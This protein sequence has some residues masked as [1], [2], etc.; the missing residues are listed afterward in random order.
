[1]FQGK[2]AGIELTNQRHRNNLILFL[3]L[4]LNVIIHSINLGVEPLWYDEIVSVKASLLDFGHVKHMAEWD[5]NPPFYYY[6]LWVWTKLFGITELAVR[7]LNL[8]FH[9]G[10]VILLFHFVSKN[11]GNIIAITTT[12]LFSFNDFVFY[13][14]HEARC[15]TLT[16]FL[17]IASGA[18]FFKVLRNPSK[19]TVFSLGLVNFLIIYTH[20]IAGITF[21]IQ[22]CFV[23]I[24]HKNKTISYLLSILITLILVVIRFSKK[25]FLLIFGFNERSSDFW[26]Q[27]AT[28]SDLKT[29]FTQLLSN[30]FLSYVLLGLVFLSIISFIYFNKRFNRDSKNIIL[31][32]F[33]LSVITVFVLYLL[34]SITPLFLGRYLLFTIPFFCILIPLFSYT[35]KA[36]QLITIFLAFGLLFT[37]NFS[38]KKPTNYRLAVNVTKQLEKTLN[39][40]I[41]IQTKDVTA[42]FAYYYDQVIFKDYTNLNSNLK[43]LN[44]FE[45]ED[46]SDFKEI[47]INTNEPL[48]LLQTFEKESDSKKILEAMISKGYLY[49]ATNAIKGV[50]LTCFK[51]SK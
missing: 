48:I 25:Q 14:T 33:G 49:H 24:F 21:F 11:I 1:M 9:L 43:A 34:G 37:I 50:K 51:K 46:Y 23:L 4:I 16:T 20:Y 2:L 22:I 36:I 29:V 42:L 44:I 31:Y 3:I 7:S 12:L 17:I 18:I 30:S 40:K 45:V 35:N 5:N 19:L 15:Y 8:I 41:I 38:P 6:C 13:Y 27:K 32:S 10:S 26:L 47:P 39:P 28:A